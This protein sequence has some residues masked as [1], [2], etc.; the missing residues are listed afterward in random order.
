[1]GDDALV[2]RRELKRLM[3]R[4]NRPGLIH[5]GL[6]VLLLAA[7][8]SL[9]WM[10]GDNAWLLIPAMFAHGIVVVHHF[11]LQHECSHYTAF[12]SRW[13]CNL[14]AHICGLILVIPPRFFRYEHCDHHTY[15][16]L[17]GR[18]PE[19]IELPISLWK[20]LGYLSS[21]PYWRGQFGGMFRRARGVL[22]NDEQR[23]LP[24][25]EWGAVILESRLMIAGYLAIIVAMAATGWTGPI[26]YWWLP[27]FMAEPLM[28]F[29][30]MTEH[31]GRPTV[32]DMRVNTRTNVVSLPWRFLAWNMNYHAE[33]HYAASVPFHGLGALHDRIR[34]RVYVEK[35]GYLSAHLDILGQIFGTRPRAAE[36]AAGSDAT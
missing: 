1:M 16:N 32:D 3:K 33:H 28:R 20:Y 17:T 15:T 14:L 9:I 35:H 29:I 22:T 10:A 24:R 18:D 11:A 27:M 12:R 5:L 21:V 31:V 13:I 26:F 23:F 2:P 34:D 25:E 6:W 7:T 30:R 19:M 4:S 36:G 8:G